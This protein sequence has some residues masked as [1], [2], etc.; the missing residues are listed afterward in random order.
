MNYPKIYE[1]IRSHSWAITPEYMNTM[2]A[3][4]NGHG[5]KLIAMQMAQDRNAFISGIGKPGLA[6][7]D[8]RGVI[9]PYAG[10]FDQV[11]G[12]TSLDKVSALFEIAMADPSVNEILFII[13]SPGGEITGLANLSDTIYS[14]REK[15]KVAAYVNGMAASAAYWIASACSEI[16]MA[17][18]ASVGSI[19]VM[20]IYEDTTRA[21]KEAGID[22]LILRSSLAPNKN[23]DP[24]TDEGREKVQNRID[25]LEKVFIQHVAR[26]RGVDVET[27]INTFGKGDVMIAKDG[28]L[29]GLA[30]K[31][32]NIT[33]MFK[34]E[35]VDTKELQGQVSALQLEIKSLQEANEAEIAKEKEAREKAEK[36]LAEAEALKVTEKLAAISDT[37]LKD[38]FITPAEKETVSEFVN[39]LSGKNSGSDDTLEK[40]KSFLTVR[41]KQFNTEPEKIEVPAVA[42]VELPDG[43]RNVDPQQLLDASKI[44]ALADEKKLPYL[45]AA[46]LYYETLTSEGK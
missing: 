20:A 40:F 28:I 7:I 3:V 31:L 39:I 18:T 42:Q 15:K 34:K 8:I 1:F 23:L 22:T 32:A 45:E 36:E 6:V 33:S 25:S 26:N 46:K 30:D 35:N 44:K 11:S 10:M 43:T 16:T 29:N 2:L 38:A 5:D 41:G 24:F 14:A 12:L 17:E 27:V 4:L 13:D 19:G 21:D 37:L 9:V